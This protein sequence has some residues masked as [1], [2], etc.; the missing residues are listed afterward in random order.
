MRLEEKWNEIGIERE[1][2]MVDLTR[3]V[4]RYARALASALS[5]GRTTSGSH[6]DSLST[7]GKKKYPRGVSL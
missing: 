2:A 5:C 7:E 4:T 1:W 3:E 6:H